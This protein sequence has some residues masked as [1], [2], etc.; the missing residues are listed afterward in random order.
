MKNIAFAY[1]PSL[2]DDVRSLKWFNLIKN[3]EQFRGD[4]LVQDIY[5][6]VIIRM[7]EQQF[8]KAQELSRECVRKNYKGC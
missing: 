2:K 4:A 5:K 6:N 7:N 3:T 1:A 8:E